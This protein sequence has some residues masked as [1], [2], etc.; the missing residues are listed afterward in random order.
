MLTRSR[1]RILY[2]KDNEGE[3]NRK[4]ETRITDCVQG[5]ELK[6]LR[7]V[8]RSLEESVLTGPEVFP[9]HENDHFNNLISL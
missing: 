2:R 1:H 7:H 6:A 4:Q 3:E 9:L 8:N 5:Q